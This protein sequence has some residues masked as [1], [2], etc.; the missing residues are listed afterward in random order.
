MI[1]GAIFDMDGTLLD[2]MPAWENSSQICL[3]P[4]GVTVTREDIHNLEGKTQLQ[5]LTYFAEKYP[6]IGKT[7]AQLMEE[8]DALMEKRY[9][10]IAVP[11]NGIE[12]LLAHY[13]KKGVAMCVASLTDRRHCEKALAYP[14]LLGYFSFLMTAH[15]VG[16]SKRHPDIYLQCAEKLGF[17]PSEI[18]VFEDAPYAAETAKKAGFAVCGVREKTYRAGE[19]QL[20]ANSD[21]IVDGDF[22]QVPE[23]YI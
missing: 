11:R 16:A 6:Q 15:E 13:Q 8:F 23:L 10:E 1:K 7:G 2:S 17:A 22:R 3:A 18:L 9:R 12:D 20:R 19:A 14:G 21:W 4:Y 5:F